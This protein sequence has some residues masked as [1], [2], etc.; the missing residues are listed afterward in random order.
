[1]NLDAYQGNGTEVPRCVHDANA[2]GESAGIVMFGDGKLTEKVWLRVDS[3]LN[4][5]VRA[6]AIARRQRIQDVARDFMALGAHHAVRRMG[7]RVPEQIRLMASNF[8]Q[9]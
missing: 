7:K 6:V 5:A 9:R 3:E 2:E 8:V 1:M 4:M